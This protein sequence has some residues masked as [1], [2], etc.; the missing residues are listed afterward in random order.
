MGLV[1]G[2]PVGISFT[3]KAGADGDLLRYGY[4]LEQAG[5]LRE[6]PKYLPTVVTGDLLEPTKVEKFSEK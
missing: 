3:G 1:S 2:L 5:K 6:T 4:A